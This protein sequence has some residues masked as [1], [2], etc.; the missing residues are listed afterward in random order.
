MMKKDI[1]SRLKKST[2]LSRKQLIWSFLVSLFFYSILSFFSRTK[3]GEAIQYNIATNIE[4]I[5][6]HSVGKSPILN[7][8]IKILSIGDRSLSLLNRNNLY[9]HEWAKIL[10]KIS[11]RDP[12][13]IIIDKI[14]GVANFKSRNKKSAPELIQKLE[15]PIITGAF[16]SPNRIPKRKSLDL[17][18]SLKNVEL[19]LQNGIS[20][21]NQVVFY[22]PSSSLRKLRKYESINTLGLKKVGKSLVY[23]RHNTLED[24]FSLNGMYNYNGHLKYNPFVVIEDSDVVF[25]HAGMLT[26]DTIIVENEKIYI[27]DTHLSL[28]TKG[29]ALI[30]LID[31]KSFYKR[32]KKLLNIK[33]YAE[34][35]LPGDTVIILPN[36]YT[37]GTDFHDSPIGFVPG[38]FFI[39]SIVNSVLS[40][41]WLQQMGYEWLQL[42]FC[43]VIGLISAIYLSSFFYWLFVSI[44]S[45]VLIGTGLLSFAYYNTEISWWW[46]L[47]C[48]LSI[49][50]SI[51]I[52]KS[53]FF[54]KFKEIN[55]EITDILDSIDQAIFTFNKDL[56]LNSEFSKQA[57]VFFD[58]NIFHQRNRLKQLFG[59]SEEKN[60]EFI[61]WKELMFK[62]KNL[63]KWRKFSL[64]CPVNELQLDDKGKKRIV[65]L[66][67]KP[68]LRNEKISK[69]MILGNDVTEQIEMEK[70][71]K[72][73]KE[74]HKEKMER[75]LSFL[76]NDHQVVFDFINE[77]HTVIRKYM[78]SSGLD[79]LFQDIDLAYREIHTLKGNAG[80]FGFHKFAGI[81]NVAEDY[82]SYI[83]GLNSRDEVEQGGE[84]KWQ[85]LIQEMYSELEEIVTIK[86]T[87]FKDFENQISID[88]KDFDELYDF[89]VKQRLSFEG[90]N[91]II[92]KL[93]MLNTV[94]FENLTRKYRNIIANFTASNGKSINDLK[95]LT[96]DI[97]VP[98]KNVNFI[99]KVLVHLIRNSMDHGIEGSEQRSLVN[100]GPGNIEVGYYETEKNYK[101]VL[102]DDGKG[103][104][105]AKIH[106]QAIEKGIISRD[107]SLTDQEKIELIFKPGFSTKEDANEISGRGVGMDAVQNL[108]Q[109]I[110]GKITV[111]SQLGK[112]TSFHLLIP[113]EI[114]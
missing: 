3:F 36:M 33:L 61:Q 19:R 60:S 44:F 85:G 66:E 64:L 51:F 75:L 109:S 54:E 56:S 41:Q 57:G 80:S 23:A 68:I 34:S 5:F 12:S 86:K 100:K 70:N 99:D 53:M 45:I 55:D 114:Y 62:D 43:S 29:E 105:P 1:L 40:G 24:A 27:N 97:K 7:E 49:S 37:G 81:A 6:K 39:V 46:S 87:I 69:I 20:Q 11:E 95:V 82:M 13:K 77:S 112:G 8:K 52:Y 50:I 98:K 32:L 88:K 16:I 79:V 93:S 35:I 107:I 101:I 108:L 110:G 83:R 73:T 10:S 9:L 42:G 25:P 65:K 14:F 96:P 92:K 102:K 89:V 106:S 74:K 15:T 21:L 76:N 47:L 18:K 67:Y 59:M 48:F 28:N 90:M 111:E 30:N 31:K 84:I 4:F 72:I 63:K 78:E 104:D 22:Q 94:K 58:N 91:E 26:A 113:K 38:G 103:I 2:N 17:K 71:L